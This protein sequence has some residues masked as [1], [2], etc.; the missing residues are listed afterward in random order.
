MSSPHI[1]YVLALAYRCNLEWDNAHEAYKKIMKN[2]TTILDYRDMI[3]RENKK[4]I[5]GNLLEDK[6]SINL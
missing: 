4:L 3:A 1:K 6:S 2:E 5:E